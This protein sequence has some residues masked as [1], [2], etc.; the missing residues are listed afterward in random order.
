MD[1]RLA[2]LPS[3][4]REL[5][6]QLPASARAA[7]LDKLL[8]VAEI[9][10]RALEQRDVEV[11]LVRADARQKQRGSAACTVQVLQTAQ[12]PLSTC[13][14]VQPPLMTRASASREC[15]PR[16]HRRPPMHRRPP[17]PQ[18]AFCLR[19]SGPRR[20]PS[21]AFCHR[22]CSSPGRTWRSPSECGGVPSATAA[23]RARQLALVYARSPPR[24]ACGSHRLC[25]CAAATVHCG[26]CDRSKIALAAFDE[27][28]AQGT[29]GAEPTQGAAADIPVAFVIAEIARLDYT[30]VSVAAAQSEERRAK[31]RAHY[32][33]GSHSS[34]KHTTGRSYQAVG[35]AVTAD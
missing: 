3:N 9:S 10:Y 25:H 17:T 11:I 7:M 27:K 14:S 18:P 8:A 30:L 32:W 28:A 19:R 13:S 31:Y 29:D 33:G 22:T 1:E 34:V 16:T 23:A 5:V 4:V 20:L 2:L 24:A 35:R 12:R 26:D 15:L 6:L 21:M